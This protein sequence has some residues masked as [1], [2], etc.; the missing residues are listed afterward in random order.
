[1]SGVLGF[2]GFVACFMTTRHLTLELCGLQPREDDCTPFYAKSNFEEFNCLL[3]FGSYAVR[4]RPRR[5]FLYFWWL[6]KLDMC[7]LCTHEWCAALPPFRSR[8]LVLPWVGGPWV[9]L[10]WFYAGRMAQFVFWDFWVP[11][12]NFGCPQVFLI[13]CWDLSSEIYCIVYWILSRPLRN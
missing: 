12:W 5:L 3:F 10:V 1:M 11:R 2:W 7:D 9:P 4:T 8:N 13:V 6:A